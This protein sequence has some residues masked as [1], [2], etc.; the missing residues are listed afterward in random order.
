ML[1]EVRRR[2]IA[3]GTTSVGPHRDEIEVTLDG[4]PAKTHASQGQRRSVV[5]ALKAA[6]LETAREVLGVPPV[7]LLDDVFSDL[8]AGRRAVL[9]EIAREQGG[10]VFITC[11]EFEESGKLM[12]GG[13]ALFRVESGRVRRQDR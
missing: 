13:A 5:I 10:Q 4:T 3:R 6:V 1:P 2:D 7:L 9:V 12:E 8:D 11:T